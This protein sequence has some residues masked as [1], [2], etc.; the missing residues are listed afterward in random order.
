M[1]ELPIR[2]PVSAYILA[3][4]SAVFVFFG[5]LFALGLG[6]AMLLDALDLPMWTSLI[7]A[8]FVWLTPV[9]LALL[10]GWQTL[11]QARKKEL[12]KLSKMP[13]RTCPGCGEAFSATEPCCPVC[14]RKT[15]TAEAN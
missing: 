11:Q 4:I 7:A 13:A 3:F 15:A 10:S 14:G 6:T 12:S 5:G 1:N 9:V 2:L 8:P